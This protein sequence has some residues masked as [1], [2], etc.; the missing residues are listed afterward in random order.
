MDD[1]LRGLRRVLARLLARP[2]ELMLEVGAGGELLVARLRALISALLLPVPLLGLV[3]G[4]ASYEMFAGLGGAVLANVAAQAWLA[5]ARRRRRHPW[6]PF[7]TGTYD[8]SAITL[9]LVVLAL[10]DPSA[11]LN[12]TVVWC[13]YLLAIGMTGLRNDG[14]LTLYVGALALAQFALLAIAVFAL[15]PPSQLASPAYGIASPVSVMHRCMLLAIA[16]LLT[17]TVVYRMQ[18]LVEMSG[19]DSLT[20]LPNRAWLLQRMPHVFAAARNG[21]GTLA[22]ALIDIDRF[23]RINDEAGHLAGDRVLRHFGA[24]ISEALQENEMA[25]RIGGQEFV[26]VLH[27][28]AG[29]AWERLDRLRRAIA[30][31]RFLPE[32]GDDALHLSFS[33]GL[34]AWPADGGHLSALLGVADRRLR[35]AKA[36][37]GDRIAARDG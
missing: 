10:R 24:A 16:T 9:L 13:I 19:H 22:L 8:V 4:E 25:V 20:G 21:G 28:P 32:L 17:A 36:G 37:G 23:Q 1:D 2:D 31:R 15:A 30:G 29:G 18:R 6:L 27:G 3:L 14:R 7:A 34:A 11:G 5:L 35:A 12:S 26:M 33:A